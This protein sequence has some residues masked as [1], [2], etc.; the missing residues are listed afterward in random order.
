MEKIQKIEAGPEYYDSVF[1]NSLYD[2]S[3]ESS[4]LHDIIRDLLSLMN[5]NEKVFE[6]GCGT[7][8]I[9]Q[10]LFSENKCKQY[11]G[12]DFS[13]VA[14]HKAKILNKFNTNAWI[15]KAD[16]YGVIDNLELFLKDSD[17]IIATEVLEHIRDLEVLDKLSKFRKGMKIIASLPTFDEQSHLRFF[18]ND[19]EIRNY[20][21]G[22]IDIVYMK[23]IRAWWLFVGTIV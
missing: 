15:F 3:W 4:R 8:Q 1:K 16:V 13:D 5:G 23:K 22:V 9:A 12:F 2:K 18:K 11:I 14:I 17:T 19:V 7:G 20:Y 6:I 21:E 10:A